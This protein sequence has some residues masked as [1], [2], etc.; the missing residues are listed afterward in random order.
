[1][2]SPLPSP[3][4]LQDTLFAPLPLVEPARLEAGTQ[5]LAARLPASLRLGTSS[6]SFPGWTGLVW[7]G[8]HD[9]ATLAREGLA[10]YA[11]HPLLRTVSLDRSY[12]RP[13]TAAQ[14]AAL[15]AQV[16]EDFR[17]VVKAPAMI[18]DG[19]QRDAGGRP[20]GLNPGF[21]D[22]ALTTEQFVQ[23]VLEGMGTRAGALVIEIG[24][25]PGALK[26]DLPALLRRLAHLLESL[27]AL[28][29]RAPEAVI[30][31]EVRDPE[32]LVPA[33]RDVLKATGARYCLGLHPRLPPI[34]AQLPLLRAMWPGAF[35]CRWNLNRRH[36]AHGYEAAKA[37]YAPFDRLVDPDPATREA[38]ARIMHGTAAAGHPVLVTVNNKA[39]GSAPC[40]V[41][42]LARAVAPA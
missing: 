38:L 27:P 26:A 3:E 37:G 4:S 41:V 8:R 2:P 25:L 11:R 9:E 39:E 22:P 30:A 6:W 20:V 31:V 12:Y 19:A 28:A 10:A 42:E 17:F 18:S 32:W 35:V 13:M 29:P 24:P 34:E 33:F 5:A 40:S 1:M 23:P 36:G 15:A 7:A 16:P 21:L 14:F